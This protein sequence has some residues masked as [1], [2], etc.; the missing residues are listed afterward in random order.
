MK[1]SIGVAIGSV[2]LATGVAGHAQDGYPRKPITMIV[3]AAPGGAGDVIARA[4]TPQLSAILGKMVVVDNKPG[5]SGIIGATIAA[6]AAPDGYTIIMA[7]PPSIV[8]EPHYRKLEYAPLR[9]FAAVTLVTRSPHILVVHPS[10]PVKSVKEL[11]ALGKARPDS[12]NFASSGRGAPSGLAGDVFN[13]LTGLD[14]VHV[15][16]KGAGPATAALLGGQT[17]MMFAPMPVA[18]PYLHDQRL[19][20]LAVTSK[21]RSAAAPAVPTL[22]E[23]GVA[24]DIVSFY[25]VLAPAHTPP[26]IVDRLQRAIAEVLKSPN[27]HDYFSKGGSD[28]V[29][30]TPAEFSTYLRGQ[31]E[32]FGKIVKDLGL[33]P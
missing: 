20:P 31:Y 21:D 1:K 9:D 30:D 28:V 24:E 16:F 7:P 8:V 26:A 14:I 32:S 10:L 11:I 5:A 13:K 29:G 19:R 17:E 6:H 3:P 2:L 27:V 15:P 12:L 25:G 4:I 33:K 18:L 22:M 23:S